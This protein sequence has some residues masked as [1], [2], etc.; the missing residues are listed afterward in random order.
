MYTVLELCLQI[1]VYTVL[2]LCRADSSVHG[3]WRWGSLCICAAVASRRFPA[4]ASQWRA[5][6]V[7]TKAQAMHG[8]FERQVRQHCHTVGVKRMLHVPRVPRLTKCSA[9]H[10]VMMIPASAEAEKKCDKMGQREHT[11]QCQHSVHSA[12]LGVER[13]SSLRTARN[14]WK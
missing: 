3:A 1:A 7:Y 9:T 5:C 8:A 6:K 12:G 14:S 13:G 2:E 11:Q 10:R 4:A